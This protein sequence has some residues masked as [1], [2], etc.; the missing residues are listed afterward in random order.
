MFIYVKTEAVDL[1]CRPNLKIGVQGINY[2]ITIRFNIKTMQIS[3]GVEEARHFN[4]GFNV[5]GRKK[6][7]TV[8]KHVH[9][10][11]VWFTSSLFTLM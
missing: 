7:K 9:F 1:L 5:F 8:M 11:I 6:Y 3:A 2:F 10:L 4:E